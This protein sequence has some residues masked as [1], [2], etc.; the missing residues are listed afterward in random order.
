[1]S[2]AVK[3]GEIM[4]S[5]LKNSKRQGNVGIGHAIAYFTTQGYTVSIPLTDSQEYDLIVD[6]NGELKTIQ[7]KTTQSI[8]KSG[9]YRVE[10]RTIT[11]Y[12]TTTTE[13][14]PLSKVDFL[15]VLTETSNTYLIPGNLVEGKSG[16]CL[17]A[18]YN[19]YL[20]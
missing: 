16:I 13:K 2:S 15:F 11:K 1:M 19:T 3:L 12:L 20:V 9:A 7:V 14:K 8:D 10:L 18:K 17:G 5:D 4:F 6:I